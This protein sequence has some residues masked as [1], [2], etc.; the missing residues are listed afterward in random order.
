MSSTISTSTF[1][2]I[3]SSLWYIVDRV[4]RTVTG[5][6]ARTSKPRRAHSWKLRGDFDHAQLL[7]RN[8]ARSIARHWREFS[9]FS[10]MA[11]AVRKV[12]GERVPSRSRFRG[13]LTIP[14][15]D[16]AAVDEAL[17][18]YRQADGRRPRTLGGNT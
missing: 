5:A 9:P 17:S 7:Y 10:V 6:A 1:C 12:I 4:C 11:N 13:T 14:F 18:T 16:H 8:N 15:G 3:V 2:A